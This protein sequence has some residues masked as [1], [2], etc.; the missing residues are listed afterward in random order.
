MRPPAGPPAPSP[1]RVVAFALYDHELIAADAAKNFA[2]LQSLRHAVGAFAEQ[3]VAGR[4]PVD[5]VDLFET[6]EI[7][8]EH[9][10]GSSVAFCLPEGAVQSAPNC[11]SVGQPGQRI[12]L[13]KLADYLLGL[14]PLLEIADRVDLICARARF[15][16]LPYHLHWNGA[17]RSRRHQ[18]LDAM[19]AGAT[20]R[21]AR[22]IEQV[23]EN[24]LSNNDLA[25]LSVSSTIR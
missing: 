19:L 13:R 2:R 3:L 20:C 11:R 23:A 7:D 15:V 17:A 4:V 22:R 8:A 6:V 9:G 1:R 21:M 24:A 18:R 12:V 14:T 5:I 10:K 25:G 16:R